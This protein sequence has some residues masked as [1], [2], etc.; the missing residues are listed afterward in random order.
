MALLLSDFWGGGVIVEFRRRFGFVGD[1]Y[2]PLSSI[3]LAAISLMRFATNIG[4]S[5]L[6]SICSDFSNL[7]PANQVLNAYIPAL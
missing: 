2:S 7:V 3:I 5:S 1:M 4:M 6:W